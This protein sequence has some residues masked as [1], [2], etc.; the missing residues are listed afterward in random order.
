MTY[1]LEFLFFCILFYYIWNII[2]KKIIKKFFFFRRDV[3]SDKNPTHRSSK[4]KKIHWDAETV[5]YEE[6][7]EE[8]PPR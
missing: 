7:N 6:V 1:F 2:K 3:S 4:E 5:D 8:N